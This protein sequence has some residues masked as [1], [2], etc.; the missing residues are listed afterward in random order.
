MFGCSNKAKSIAFSALIV[1]ICKY[2]SS[3]WSPHSKQNI[4]LLKSILHSGTR[5]VCNSHYD[6]I[7]HQWTPSSA[8]C[9]ETLHWQSLSFCH[10]VPS[11]VIAHDIIHY[12]SCIPQHFLPITSYQVTFTTSISPVSSVIH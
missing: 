2:T 1:P 3:V 6:P 9:C 11:L 7:H 4:N 8:S 5:C 12:R 10:N